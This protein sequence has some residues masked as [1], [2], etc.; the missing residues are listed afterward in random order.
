MYESCV[1]SWRSRCAL[2][3][4]RLRQLLATLC[5]ILAASCCICP[6]SLLLS[7]ASFKAGSLADTDSWCRVLL[8]RRS[9]DKLSEVVYVFCSL[10]R[11]GGWPT[12][13]CKSAG[14]TAP[15]DQ[16]HPRE[17]VIGPQ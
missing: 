10:S 17:Q 1:L 11:I 8:Q 6:Q 5:F 2:L 16:T 4:S 3:T 12:T 13:S 9:A 15:Q 14:Y 7:T